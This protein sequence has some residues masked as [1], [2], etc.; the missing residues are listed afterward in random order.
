MIFRAQA[1]V[2]MLFYCRKAEGRILEKEFELIVRCHSNFR[3][4]FHRSC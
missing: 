2:L 1:E 4:G 3:L